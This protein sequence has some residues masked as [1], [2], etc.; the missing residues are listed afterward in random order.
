MVVVVGVWECGS[1][2]RWARCREGVCWI[3]GLLHRRGLLSLAEVTM[4]QRLLVSL[5]VGGQRSCRWRRSFEGLAAPW[6]GRR[7]CWNA[8]LETTLLRSCEPR[9]EVFEELK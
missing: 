1:R 7:G 9:I 2:R 4:V 5:K 3:G 6:W 8:M